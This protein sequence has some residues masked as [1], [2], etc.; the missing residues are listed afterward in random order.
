[1]GVAVTT[2]G[3]HFRNKGLWC[4][5]CQPPLVTQT[6]IPQKIRLN[7]RH[8]FVEAT[9][10]QKRLAKILFVRKIFKTNCGRLAVKLFK[11]AQEN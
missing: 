8:I 4:Q 3:G 11:R 7:E 2:L 5:R 9:P 6:T 1:M 10:F